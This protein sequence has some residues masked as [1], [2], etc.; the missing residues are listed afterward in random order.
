[1]VKSHQRGRNYTSMIK[2]ASPQESSWL[3]DH[4]VATAWN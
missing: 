1:M 4:G 3:A 2:A